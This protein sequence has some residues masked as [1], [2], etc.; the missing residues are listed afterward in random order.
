MKK[1]MLWAILA[2]AGTGLAAYFI[3]RKRRNANQPEGV[4]EGKQGN[5]FTKAFTRTKEYAHDGIV[6]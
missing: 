4:P 5:R 1:K 3:I 6:D 2:A